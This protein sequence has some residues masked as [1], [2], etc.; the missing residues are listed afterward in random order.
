MKRLFLLGA[1]G[2]SLILASCPA[3]SETEGE[4][5]LEELKENL[6]REYFEVG[7]LLQ[8]VADGQLERSFPGRS[9]FSVANLRLSVRGNLDRRFGYFAQTSLTRAPAI[10]DAKA[11]Y[12]FGGTLTLDAGFFKA[13]FSR[14]Y[15][16]SASAIDFVNRSRAA[17]VLSPG[18]QIGVQ[19]RGRLSDLVDLRY[20]LGVF[21]GNGYGANVN[22]NNKFMYCARL[23]ATPTGHGGAGGGRLEV[24]ANGAYSEDDMARLSALL[25]PFVFDVIV[26]SGRRTVFGVDAR[27]E[28]GGFMVAGEYIVADLD[29]TITFVIDEREAESMRPSGFHLT[30]GYMLSPALQL[31]GRLDSFRTDKGRDSSEWVIIG[32]NYWPS[33]AA[34]LQFNYIVNTDDSDFKHHQLL[35]N[36]Q[37]AF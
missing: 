34:E 9:G 27:Y 37:L 21:N 25:N 18:R 19:A 7:F 5:L 29:G 32:L 3:F 17:A 15:L 33:Q 1:V 13:P 36:A 20:A 24:G 14:E 11:Y 2:L 6:K 26:F 4:P 10:L 8:F 16:T 28:S 12:S 31:L 30:A 23:A 35:I 22:D